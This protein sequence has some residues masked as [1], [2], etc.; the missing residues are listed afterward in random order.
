MPID[1]ACALD[2]VIRLDAVVAELT[3][4]S[5]RMLE[6]AA[7]ARGLAGQTE[8]HARAAL[9]FTDRAD[10]WARDVS[11]LGCLAETARIAAMR[12]RDRAAVRTWSEC[13]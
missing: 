1:T 9:A 4:L 11:G 7:S 8:W 2:T 6:A 10:R 3:L 5:D 13:A 12:A